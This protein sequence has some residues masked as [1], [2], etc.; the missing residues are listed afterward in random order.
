[1]IPFF[2][3]VLF[4]V[5]IVGFYFLALL[6]TKVSKFD[7]LEKKQRRM[8]EEM[9]DSI[10]AYLSELKDENDR[11]IHRLA[12]MEMKVEKELANEHVEAEPAPIKQE[13]PSIPIVVPKRPVNL[14]LKSYGEATLLKEDAEAEE[15]DLDDRGKVLNLYSIGKSVEDIAK[16]LGKGR[17]EVE[18]I[19]KFEK[20]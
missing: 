3:L 8:M 11:L 5:Q 4:I 16:E 19:L 2:L 9:D 6:Y 10:G 1:M 7:D 13:M 20:R 15:S 14:A 17:T 12:T 18:L